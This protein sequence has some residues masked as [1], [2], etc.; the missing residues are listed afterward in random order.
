MSCVDAL[1]YSLCY[2]GLGCMLIEGRIARC[3][4]E[5]SFISTHKVCKRDESGVQMGIGSFGLI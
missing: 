1:G 3:G 4:K 5:G 2:V